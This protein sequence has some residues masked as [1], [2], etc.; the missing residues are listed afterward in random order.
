MLE[1]IKYTTISQICIRDLVFYSEANI[2]KLKKFC[3]DNSITYLPS[4]DRKT[5]Y[6]LQGDEFVHIREI[7]MELVCYPTDFIFTDEMIEKFNI[8]NHDEVMFVMEDNL[9]KGVVHIVD[10][11]NDDLYV[12]LFRMLLKFENYLRKTLLKSG[13]TND[14]FIDWIGYKSKKSH[15]YKDTLAKLLKES[16]IKKRENSNPFQTFLLR[17]LV[18]FAIKKR[19]LST[20]EIDL[21]SVTILRNWIAHS[22]DVIAFNPNSDHPVYNIE[23]LKTFIASVRSFFRSFDALEIKLAET[24]EKSITYEY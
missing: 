3:V 4:P 20:D 17:D 18:L 15:H 2:E 13:F 12:E 6:R 10:Y 14:D 16:E 23:G 24:I 11:N 19:I 9:I 1:P 22:K 21:D 7:P 8:G 5:C